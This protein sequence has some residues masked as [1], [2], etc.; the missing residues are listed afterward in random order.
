MRRT[1]P[2]REPLE[3]AFGAASTAAFSS[4]DMALELLPLPPHRAAHQP[5][6]RRAPGAWR[7]AAVL[8]RTGP[9]RIALGCSESAA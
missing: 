5:R 2:N 1:D 3:A 8:P 4:N 6:R 7:L 9:V